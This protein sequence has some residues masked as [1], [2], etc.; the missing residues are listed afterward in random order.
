MA[1]YCASKGAILQLSK[2]LAVDHAR[3]GLR[4]N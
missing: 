1:A 3:D 2:V 4:V